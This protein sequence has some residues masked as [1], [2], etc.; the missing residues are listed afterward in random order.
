MNGFWLW[1]EDELNGYIHERY[2]SKAPLLEALHKKAARLF[3]IYMAVGGLPQAVKE[4]LMSGDFGK[5]LLRD[6]FDNL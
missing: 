6:A 5:I 3:R 2:A 1:G 4:Y